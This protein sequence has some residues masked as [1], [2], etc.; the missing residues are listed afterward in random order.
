MGTWAAI[1]AGIQILFK[2]LELM[3]DLGALAQKKQF[4][5]WLDDLTLTVKEMDEADDLRKK[6][7]AA[8]KLSDLTRRI[9]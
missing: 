6:L 5:D 2:L 8:R 3:R 1:V 9:R 7:N 4:T